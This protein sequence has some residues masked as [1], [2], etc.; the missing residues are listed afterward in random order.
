MK[1]K[2]LDRKLCLFFFMLTAVVGACAI[3]IPTSDTAKA[4][5]VE[6]SSV[7]ANL[8]SLHRSRLPKKGVITVH[9]TVHGALPPDASATV[10]LG[11]AT[12]KP[13]GNNISYGQHGELTLSLRQNSTSFQFQV[14]ADRQTM[15]GSIEARA[16]IVRTTGG[17]D[18]LESKRTASV[19]LKTYSP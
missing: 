2:L 11:T 15:T 12:Q 5:Y 14:H 7:A 6:I 19:W 17:I 8:D 10:D 4:P 18:V 1:M 3:Q 9:I 16:T 13:L